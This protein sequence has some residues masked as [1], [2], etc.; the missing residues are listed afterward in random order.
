[1]NYENIWKN[2]K[3][4]IEG[5]KNTIIKNAEIEIVAELRYRICKSCEG[6]ST[7]CASIVSECCSKCGCSLKFKTRSLESSCPIEKWPKLTD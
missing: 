7:N 4:I 2:K 5:V 6:Y 1:M 3:Q